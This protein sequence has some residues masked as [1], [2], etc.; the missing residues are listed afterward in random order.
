MS[1]SDFASSKAGHGVVKRNLCLALLVTAALGLSACGE[2]EKKPGQALASVNG[3]E[4]TVLQLNEELQRSGVTEAQQKT[5]SKQ[6]LESLIDRQLLRN[7]AT[8]DGVDRDPKVMQAIE[9]AKALIVAQA[10]L[11]KRVGAPA[12]PTPE[13]INAYF[14][15]HP[16]FFTH[17]KAFDLRQLVLATAAVSD[18]L[19]AAI[20]GAKTLDEVAAYMDSHDIKYNRAQLV[21]SSSDLPP[22]LTK[23]LAEMS[24][25]Q[26]FIVREG[27]RTVV[28]TL[29]D[30]REVPVTLE[31][32]TPQIGQYLL[33]EKNKAAANAE[34][35]RLRAT[36]KIEYLNKPA[37]AAAAAPAAAGKPAAAAP[38]AGTPAAPA[39]DA[40]A[41]GAAGLR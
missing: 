15:A 13:E 25:G 33:N 23:R 35:A 2:K 21:R 22:E 6:V 5:A 9:R 11:Q 14:A 32:A 7:E 29:A 39:E 19:K 18:G 8:K 20:D 36:A 1:Y 17:R 38:A 16:E 4:I 26:L 34:I 3:E 27:E 40:A 28:N 37:A 30:S 24:K 31:A 12:K 41:R 10:Y